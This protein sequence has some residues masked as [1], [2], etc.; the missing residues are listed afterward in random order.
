MAH[1]MLAAQQAHQMIAQMD[2]DRY[3]TLSRNFLQRVSIKVETQE[4]NSVLGSTYICQGRL[5]PRCQ[6]PQ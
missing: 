5:Q 2:S 1:V 4:K 3:S 6:V